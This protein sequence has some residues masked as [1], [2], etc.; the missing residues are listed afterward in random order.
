MAWRI[1]YTKKE[2]FFGSSDIANIAMGFESLSQL[3]LKK[4]S[5]LSNVLQKFVILDA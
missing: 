3:L 4:G 5:F 2:G 1:T